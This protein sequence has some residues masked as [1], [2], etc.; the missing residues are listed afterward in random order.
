MA[1]TELAAIFLDCLKSIDPKLDSKVQLPTTALSDA[2]KQRVI[3]SLV[4][5]QQVMM[6]LYENLFPHTQTQL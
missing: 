5:N 3:H 6:F 1:Q 2:D 4:S